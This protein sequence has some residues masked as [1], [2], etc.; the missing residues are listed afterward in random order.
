[1][2][3]SLIEQSNIPFLTA[4]LLGVMT[5]IS[6]CPLATNITA[7]AFMARKLQSAKYTLWSGVLYTLGR[8]LSYSFILVLLYAGFASVNVARIFVGWGDKVLGPVLILIGLVLLGLIKLPVRLHSDHIERW[9][10][11]LAA[12]PYLGPLL[13]GMIFALAFCPYSG[14][15]FFGVLVPLVLKT[16]GGLLLAPLFAIGTALPVLVMSLLLAYSVSSLSAVF[17]IVGKVEKVVRY[18]VAV[19]FLA[20]GAYYLRYLIQYLINL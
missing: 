18:T 9:K 6:P 13:L 8:A 3:S 12:W 16:N 1:M 14:V 7:V 5:S 20:V 4:F 2:L 10:E 19:T 11:K 17:N 15:L